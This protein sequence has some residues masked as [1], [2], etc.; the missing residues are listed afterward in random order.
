MPSA[1]TRLR[2]G[3][4]KCE[5]CQLKFPIFG[6]P[7]DGKA[8]WYAICAKVHAGVVDVRHKKI[9]R[10]LPG[11]ARSAFELPSEG[12]AR[13]CGGACATAHLQPPEGHFSI[14]SHGTW[15]CVKCKLALL[16][17]VR[18]SVALTCSIIRPVD[19]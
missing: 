6:L 3:D 18:S 19:L 13:R 12:K 4:K 8:W 17:V 1:S 16:G 11:Q 5:G 10:G 15:I 14:D 9:V 2:R 7:I